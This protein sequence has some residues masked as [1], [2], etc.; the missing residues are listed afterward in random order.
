MEVASMCVFGHIRNWLTTDIN[1]TKATFAD[2]SAQYIGENLAYRSSAPTMSGILDSIN[3]GFIAEGEYYGFG[4]FN[5][6][7]FCNA[8]AFLP[9]SGCGHFTQVEFIMII[10]L[11]FKYL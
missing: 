9:T 7:D 8:T 5:N 6:N 10:T 1:M 3:N 2:G 4:S 11:S